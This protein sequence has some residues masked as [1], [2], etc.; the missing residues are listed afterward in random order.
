[1]LSR[2]HDGF[3]LMVEAA[4]IDK[5]A[6]NMDTERWILDTIEFDRAI[7]VARLRRANGDTL[8]I[9]TADH[10]CAGVNIIGGSRVTDAD[11]ATRASGRGC[12]PAAHARRGYSTTRPA[13][14]ATK[15]MGNDG[16]PSTHERRS[17]HADR[18]RGQ[19]GPLRRLAHQSAAD[20]ATASSRSTTCRR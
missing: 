5:Q 17:S 3:V 6:H 7:E 15:S 16:Y 8:V 4:S 10:E 19:R 18:L 13:S 2:N 12:G 14:R 20:C 9:V 11:L 1:V